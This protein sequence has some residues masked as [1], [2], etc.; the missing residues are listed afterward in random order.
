MIEKD[1]D[2]AK[3]EILSRDLQEIYERQVNGKLDKNS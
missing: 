1:L 3:I 2:P